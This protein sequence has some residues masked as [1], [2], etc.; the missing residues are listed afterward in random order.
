MA[1]SYSDHQFEEPLQCCGCPDPETRDLICVRCGLPSLRAMVELPADDFVDLQRQLQDVRVELEQIVAQHQ[2][3]KA[4]AAERVES[5]RQRE[6][7]AFWTANTLGWILAVVA[8]LVIPWM[9]MEIIH[10]TGTV[11]P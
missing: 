2:E 10:G 11:A 5:K 4:K 3:K 9:V 1:L 8:L 6:I 7:I